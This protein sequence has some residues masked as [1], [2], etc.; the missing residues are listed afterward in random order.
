MKLK[1]NAELLCKERAET[2][3]Q[4]TFCARTKKFTVAEEGRPQKLVQGSEYAAGLDIAA[5]CNFTLEKG[6]VTIIDC[7]WSFAPP[8]GFALIALPRSSTGI[9]GLQICNTVGLIDN[10]YRNSVKFFMTLAPW[11]EEDY[12]AFAEGD[13]FAQLKLSYSPTITPVSV[14]APL[15]ETARGDGG[16]GSSGV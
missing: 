1:S 12:L 6:K 4:V 5:P 10:D 9:N 13:R 15:P 11:A 14:D 2:V 7:G 16:H 8:E 3:G